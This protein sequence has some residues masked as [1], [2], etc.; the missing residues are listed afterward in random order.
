MPE[1]I[2]PIDNTEEK[3]SPQIVHEAE[4]TRQNARFKIPAKMEIDGKIYELRDWSLTGCSVIDMPEEYI[5]KHTTGK[6]IFK[7]DQFETI[8]DN[9]KIE[10]LYKKENY[11]GCRFTDLTP[12]QISILNQIITAYINGDIITQD[13]I[14]TAVTKIQMYPKKKKIDEVEKKKAKL[15]LFLI[16][17]TLAVIIIFLSYIVYKKVFI[18]E[19]VNGYVDSNITT[20]RSPYPSFIKFQ[21]N[22]QTDQN[23]SNSETIAVA[24]LVGGGVSRIVSPVDGKI[25]KI[26]SKNS[27]FVN[28]GEP[29]LSIIDLNATQY[30]HAVFYSKEIKKIEI[31][32]IVKIIF[33]SNIYYGKI[34]KVLYPENISIIKSKPIENI[35]ANPRNFI[36][37]IIMPLQKID[38]K[39]IGS[40]VYVKLDTFIN[41][42]GFINEKNTNN[43]FTYIF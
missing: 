26:Y 11:I 42:L 43:F 24:Y 4:I 13:D 33:G 21:K 30:I 6:I 38:K 7:F 41:K 34:I 31:G 27:E 36:D 40:S 1:K 20:L 15:I 14:I 22:Y 39:F 16:F 3:F 18:V 23:I 5:K 17:T 12:Q 2:K 35:Y 19:S 28:T 25:F 10:C 9:L 32:Y 37:V 8:I 29:I